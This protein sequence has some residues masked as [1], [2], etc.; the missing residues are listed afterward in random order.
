MRSLTIGGWTIALALCA[1]LLLPASLSASAGGDYVLWWSI[2]GGG[3][4]GS[5]GGT[6]ELS[7]TIGQCDA[8]VSAGGNYVIASGFWSGVASSVVTSRQ[9]LDYLLGAGSLSPAQQTQA[10][11]DLTGAIDIADFIALRNLGL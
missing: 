5:S 1:V 8:G 7:G 10:D 3:G 6:Y 9:V 2:D 11:L 4:I